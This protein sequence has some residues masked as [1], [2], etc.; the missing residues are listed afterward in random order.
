MTKDE[1]LQE[2]KDG[3]KI[4]GDAIREAS[5]RLDAQPVPKRTKEELEIIRKAHLGE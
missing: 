3:M 1:M 4:I 2:I 5:A